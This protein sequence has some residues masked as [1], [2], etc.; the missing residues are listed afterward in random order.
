[1]KQEHSVYGER[2]Q[3]VGVTSLILSGI[4]LRSLGLVASPVLA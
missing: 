3:F 1:M 4:E 2:G